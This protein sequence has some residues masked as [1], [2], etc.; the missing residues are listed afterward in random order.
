MAWEEVRT[1]CILLLHQAHA[2]YTLCFVFPVK[3]RKQFYFIFQFFSRFFF[4][5]SR[6]EMTLGEKK[7][8]TPQDS[9]FLFLLSSFRTSFS[10][11]SSHS[12]TAHTRKMA[13]EKKKK[14]NEKKEEGGAKMDVRALFMC[15]VAAV[16]AFFV[17]RELGLLTGVMES[18]TPA[19]DTII[20]S[21]RVVTP[22]GVMPA[23]VHVKEG[24][25]TKVV[26][27]DTAPDLEQVRACTTASCRPV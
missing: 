19:G 24:R 2:L 1:A 12:Y 11:A 9:R 27:S 14:K 26:R 18:I 4:S 5:L 21:Y 22:D 15:I 16:A 13:T 3:E 6:S 17:Q 7:N 20:F 8:K 25:I 23:A 10:E